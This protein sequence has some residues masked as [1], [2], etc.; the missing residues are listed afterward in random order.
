MH[1]WGEEK[2]LCWNRISTNKYTWDDGIK[3]HHLATIIL[4]VQ[5]Q[6]SNRC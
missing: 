2:A 1:K 6:N 5:S 3:N 4:T